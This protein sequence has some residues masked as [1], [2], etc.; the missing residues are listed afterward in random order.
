M[1]EYS[2]TTRESWGSILQGFINMSGLKQAW[3]NI[4]KQVYRGQDRRVVLGQAWVD[5]QQTTSTRARQRD[6]PGIRAVIQTGVQ[7]ESKG[8]GKGVNPETQAGIKH[9]KST[10]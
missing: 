7:T 9:G 8:L 3:S 4:D 5:D 6:N 10:R 1:A 2:V